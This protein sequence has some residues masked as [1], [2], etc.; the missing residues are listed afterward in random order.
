[1]NG[2]TVQET[3]EETGLSAHTLRYYDR[4]GLMLTPIA[5]ADNG[6]RYYS[7]EDIYWLVFLTRLRETGMPIAEIKRY[8]KLQRDGDSTIPE[9]L[10]LLEAHQIRVQKQLQETTNHLEKIASKIAHY[11]EDIMRHSAN[12]RL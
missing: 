10:A 8:V 12:G 7:N 9:R 6:H 3:S 11:K 2:L 4:V 5:R 1:M